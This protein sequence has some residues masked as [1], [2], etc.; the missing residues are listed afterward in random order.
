VTRLAIV[1][2]AALAVVAGVLIV[3]D[4]GNSDA[5]RAAASASSARTREVPPAQE[6]GPVA[7][8]EGARAAAIRAA[9]ASQRWLYL[10]DEQIR[11]EVRA[12]ATPRAAP[13]LERD[14]VAELSLAR[15][16]LSASPGRV[17][18]IVRPLAWRVESLTSEAARVSVWTVTVLSASDVAVPQADWVTLA[19]DLEWTQGRW[20]LDGIRDEPGPTPALGPRD[21]PWQPEPFDDALDRFT[22][23]ESA[24]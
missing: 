11:A 17:W 2:G 1:L 12:L 5:T 15:G 7:T 20:L 19:V 22:R 18:W 14:T 4:A 8:E 3:S 23:M 6:A 21:E 16:S 24:V 9:T 10:N 13:R